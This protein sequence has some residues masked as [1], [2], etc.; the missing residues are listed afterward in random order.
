MTQCDF[1]ICVITID[2]DGDYKCSVK[3]KGIWIHTF[4]KTEMDA[5]N[6]MFDLI[7]EMNNNQN[8]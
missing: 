6:S 3:R 2:S 1:S 8:K 5:F 4:G 7:E